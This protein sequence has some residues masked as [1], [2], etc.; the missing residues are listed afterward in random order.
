VAR[1]NLRLR[2]K[3]G[4]RLAVGGVPR[5]MHHIK[6]GGG[7][8]A[9]EVAQFR[10]TAA[11][12]HLQ[13]Q[14]LL[15]RSAEDAGLFLFKLEFGLHPFGSRRHKQQIQRPILG[16][17]GISGRQGCGGIRV[18]IAPAQG[19]DGGALLCHQKVGAIVQHLPGQVGELAR[20]GNG[21][22]DQGGAAI[23]QGRGKPAIAPI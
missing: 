16:R 22:A 3:N 7:V 2:Q 8:A 5:E 23:A 15:R 1:P 13:P 17:S 9:I 10:Q 14:G 19:H 12:L 4:F 11:L 6:G 20:G 21:K 18:G